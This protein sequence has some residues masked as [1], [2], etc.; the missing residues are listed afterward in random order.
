M[1]EPSGLTRA[2]VQNLLGISS[3][4]LHGLSGA[5]I[6]SEKVIQGGDVPDVAQTNMR[7]TARDGTQIPAIYLRP[8]AAPDQ[9]SGAR[10]APVVA[11]HQHNGEFHLGKSEPAGIAGSADMAYGLELARMGCAVIIPDL[12]CFED[13][14]GATH[15]RVGYGEYSFLAW[16]NVTEN[17][18][19][20]GLH[21]RDVSV[22]L[23][24]L[25][26]QPEVLKQEAG[27]V[28]HSL[29]GQVT[30]FAMA[31]DERLGAGVANCG[32]GTVA[33][34]FENGIEH[35]PAYFVPGI[36]SF[37]DLPRIATVLEGQTLQ[38]IAGSNDVL[39]PMEGVLAVAEALPAPSPPAKVFD[40]GHEFPMEIRQSALS[41]LVAELTNQ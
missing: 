21:V 38:V 7:L 2:A 28:G 37:G 41:W 33:S 1:V 15:D 9:S 22:A 39:F 29:G 24:W 3:E 13:R 32:V 4:D 23:T 35:N 8:A 16:R 31:T 17:K 27:I 12:A 6:Q 34:F 36:I 19:L 20:Q 10:F 40:G 25:L 30:F 5:E 14:Q 11:V 18:T 26:E